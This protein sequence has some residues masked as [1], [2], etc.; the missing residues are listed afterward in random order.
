MEKNNLQKGKSKR[1]IYIVAALAVIAGATYIS[2]YYSPEKAELGQSIRTTVEANF[3]EQA[4]QVAK[5][6]GLVSLSKESQSIPAIGEKDSIVLIHGLD[7]PGKVWMNLAPVLV[8]RNLDVWQMSYPNDQPIVESASFLFEEL[9]KLKKSGIDRITIISHSMGGL[10]SREML[11]SPGIGYGDKV[12]TGV[13]PEVTGLVMV[14]TPNHGSELARFRI[15]SEMRDQWINMVEGQGSIFRGVL[16]GTGEAKTDLLPESEFLKSL[17]ERPHPQGMRMLVIAGKVSPWEDSEIEGLFN[18]AVKNMPELGFKLMSELK[19]FSM[20]M[21]N[22][23]GDGLVT[24]ESS[25]LEG[26]AHQLVSGTHLS[27]IRNFTS[28][29]SR[30]PPAVPLILEFL[31][32][33]QTALNQ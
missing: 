12:R 33:E 4:A 14:G 20:S 17:N 5:S 11:T 30:V 9:E 22:G 6:F 26:V 24:V 1:W 18:S 16:D 28:E 31:G 10:V 21:S 13:V 2:G 29:N 23:L 32:E 8:A 3:P 25:R 19:A 27:M 15:F 7:D